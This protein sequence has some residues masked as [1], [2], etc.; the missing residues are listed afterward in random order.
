MDIRRQPRSSS[1][2]SHHTRHHNVAHISATSHNVIMDIRQQPRSSS[3][4]SRLTLL[5][6]AR[7]IE[8]HLF[9]CVHNKSD[10][11]FSIHGC[12]RKRYRS[13]TH[14]NT[15][16]ITRYRKSHITAHHTLPHITHYRTSVPR[17][18]SSTS[19][20]HVITKRKS[21]F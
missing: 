7:A 10:R 19:H 17:D 3:C 14:T 21:G 13:G 6:L 1:G 15:H 12:T 4:G 16:V 18:A 2:G 5:W 8:M 11:R 9:Q 20:I